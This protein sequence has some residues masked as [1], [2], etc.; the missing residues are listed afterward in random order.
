MKPRII[1]TPRGL[2]IETASDVSAVANVSQIK[3][4]PVEDLENGATVWVSGLRT[5]FFY[6]KASSAAPDDIDV[7]APVNGVGR[8]VKE[9]GTAS[10][11]VGTATISGAVPNAVLK[12]D[13]NRQVIAATRGQDFPDLPGN[14]GAKSS[15]LVFG[16]EYL[17][18][19]QQALANGT[20]CKICFSGDSTTDGAGV[21]DG[22]K[23]WQL[24]PFLGVRKGWTPLAL[25]AAPLTVGVNR[26]QSG[27]NTQDWARGA[28][29]QNPGAAYVVGDIAT[30]P[31]LFIVR[32]GINDPQQGRT[33]ANFESDLRA[34][35]AAI[36]ATYPVDQ[37]SIMLCTPNTTDY[38]QSNPAWHAL[39]NPVIRKAALDYQC[40]FLDIY[41]SFHIAHSTGGWMDAIKVHPG[42]WF[43]K[44]IAG[45]IADTIFPEVADPGEV[46]PTYSANWGVYPGATVPAIVR[47]GRMVLVTGLVRSGLNPPTIG[48][49]IVILPHIVSKGDVWA[50]CASDAGAS[51]VSIA[52]NDSAI[53]L[54]SGTGG[55]GF[56][57]LNVLFRVGTTT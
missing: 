7:V 43:N 52:A 40:C 11:L 15:A 47:V 9:F 56:L 2:E 29:A 53:I 49:P 8:W 45:L 14:D 46:Q 12:V 42:N 1:Q 54:R 3:V 5:S 37:A 51:N 33:L 25:S 21:D 35:L 19:F 6:D 34:G 39:I 28:T 27:K 30:A 26:G 44:R 10:S 22:Y 41:S 32:W 36:R 38:L 16:Q 13:S 57:A 55:A 17:F 24:V 48:Q 4:L 23:I 20:S 18:A 50:T 31:K